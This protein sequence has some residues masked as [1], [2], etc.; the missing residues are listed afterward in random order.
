MAGRLCR[1]LARRLTDVQWTGTAQVIRFPTGIKDLNDLHRL[2]GARFEE[3]Y[4]R[5][6]A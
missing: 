1:G 3:E 6:E 4:L 2:A 5:A